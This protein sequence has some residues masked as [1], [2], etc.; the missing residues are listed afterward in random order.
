LK[1]CGGVESYYNKSLEEMEQLSNK[2]VWF[3]IEEIY[4]KYIIVMYYDNYNNQ[5]NGEDL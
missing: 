4:G 5:A 3:K 2:V 1:A